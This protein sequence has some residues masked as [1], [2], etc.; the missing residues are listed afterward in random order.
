MA[1]EQVFEIKI[2]EGATASSL[3]TQYATDLETIKRLN[4]QI[5]NID[6]I[7]AGKPLKLPRIEPGKAPEDYRLEIQSGMEKMYKGVYGIEFARERL[8]RELEQKFPFVDVW[9]DIYA[10]IPNYY[11]Q[12]IQPVFAETKA[13]NIPALKQPIWQ[14]VGLFISQNIVQPLKERVADVAVDILQKLPYIPTPAEVFTEAKNKVMSTVIRPVVEKIEPW[15][16]SLAKKSETVYSDIKLDIKK[17][18]ERPLPGP[19]LSPESIEK[20]EVWVK[21]KVWEPIKASVATAWE[22]KNLMGLFYPITGV[23]I[24]QQEA[25]I[26]LAKQKYD[27]EKLAQLDP[28]VAVGYYLEQHDFIVKQYK[29]TISRGMVF[30]QDKYG[31]I[32]FNE[33]QTKKNKEQA[34]T[35]LA[36]DYYS[37]VGNEPLTIEA[38]SKWSSASSAFVSVANDLILN[39]RKVRDYALRSDLSIESSLRGLATDLN[40]LIEDASSLEAADP[41]LQSLESEIELKKRSLSDVDEYYNTS[42][43]LW[44]T[45]AEAL[46]GKDLTDKMKTGL[47]ETD[48]TILLSKIESL[49]DDQKSKFYSLIKSLD[50]SQAYFNTRTGLLD[51]LEKPSFLQ[52]LKEIYFRDPSASKSVLKSISTILEFKDW[53]SANEE[54]MKEGIVNRLI[55]AESISETDIIKKEVLANKA[56]NSEQLDASLKLVNFFEEEIKFGQFLQEAF[57]RLGKAAKI[58]KITSN[59]E[60]LKRQKEEVEK[61]KKFQESTEA[62]PAWQI[63]LAT[64][65]FSLPFSLPAIKAFKPGNFLTGLKL[66][67]QVFTQTR[68]VPTPFW[69]ENWK[70]NKI[71][72]ANGQKI[73]FVSPEVEGLKLRTIAEVSSDIWK[74]FIV[75]WEELMIHNAIPA[76]NATIAT[77]KESARQGGYETIVDG[78][79]VIK[80]AQKL[81][82]AIYNAF[83]QAIVDPPINLSKEDAIT[84]GFPYWKAAFDYY[85]NPKSYEEIYIKDDTKVEFKDGELRIGGYSSK[86]LLTPEDLLR[87]N[88]Q[89]K[90]SRW[91]PAG[92]KLTIPRFYQAPRFSDLIDDTQRY[93]WYKHNPGLATFV[94]EALIWFLP[95]PFIDPVFSLVNMSRIGGLKLASRLGIPPMLGL[96]E[97]YKVEKVFASTKI[98]RIVQ[99]A[100]VIDEELYK[101]F[102]LQGVAWSKFPAWATEKLKVPI[103][104]VRAEIA[105]TTILKN[106]RPEVAAAALAG[107]TEHK[108]MTNFRHLALEGDSIIEG[109]MQKLGESKSFRNRILLALYDTSKDPGAAVR[110]VFTKY[111]L[112]TFDVL[113]VGDRITVLKNPIEVLYEAVMTNFPNRN[114]LAASEAF[115]KLGGYGKD[116][117]L[118]VYND[119]SLGPKR[120]IN[121]PDKLTVFNQ[122]Y[123]MRFKNNLNY[124]EIYDEVRQTM[125]IFDYYIAE[126]EVGRI[127][128]MEGRVM[129]RLPN[130]LE[131]FQ[132]AYP[133]NLLKRGFFERS[134]DGKGW[135]YQFDPDRH[136]LREYE[137][138]GEAVSPLF[139]LRIS[140]MK[141]IPVRTVGIRRWKSKIVPEVE[142]FYVAEVDISAK[143]LKGSVHTIDDWSKELGN[144]G[145]VWDRIQKKELRLSLAPPRI[146]TVKTWISED[147]ATTIYLWNTLKSNF[148]DLLFPSSFMNKKLQVFLKGEYVPL[149][150]IEFLKLVSLPEKIRFKIIESITDLSVLLPGNLVKNGWAPFELRKIITQ[151]QKAEISEEILELFF[152]RAAFLDFLKGSP[153]GRIF[154]SKYKSEL[155]K[156]PKMWFRNEATLDLLLIQSFGFKQILPHFAFD[157]LLEDRL[158]PLQRKLLESFIERYSDHA[159]RNIFKTEQFGFKRF[160]DPIPDQIY[161]NTY[162]ESMKFYSLGY[163]EE[164]INTIIPKVYGFVPP[165]KLTKE[166][167]IIL[168]EDLISQRVEQNREMLRNLSKAKGEE[169][170]T[171][172]KGI[173]KRPLPL[174]GTQISFF[175]NFQEAAKLS[176]VE[177]AK[178]LAIIADG[179]KLLVHEITPKDKELIR[180]LK[181]RP[182]L[183]PEQ[184]WA[185]YKPLKAEKIVESPASTLADLK[186]AQYGVKGSSL[187][188]FLNFSLPVKGKLSRLFTD[189][190]L[191]R[192]MANLPNFSILPE[193]FQALPFNLLVKQRP[194]E[195]MR[196]KSVL[197]RAFKKTSLGRMF[198]KEIQK[199]T[200]ITATF[201]K[202]LKIE[203]ETF[204]KLW[205]Q[206]GFPPE[207]H[208][209]GGLLEMDDVFQEF[210][211]LLRSALN[212]IGSNSLELSIKKGRIVSVTR[213]KIFKT[214]LE[215]VQEEMGY[216]GDF[217]GNRAPRLTD[218]VASKT[219]PSAELSTELKKFL[220]VLHLDSFVDE[221]E[222]QKML[223][224]VHELRNLTSSRVRLLE[225]MEEL[226]IEIY[227]LEQLINLAPPTEVKTLKSSLNGRKKALSQISKVLDDLDLRIKMAEG[228]IES[229]MALIGDILFPVNS[230]QEMLLGF[231]SGKIKY[232][233]NAFDWISREIITLEK[234]FKSL[235]QK[236]TEF[237]KEK[238]ST[239]ELQKSKFALEKKLD[240]LK[241]LKDLLPTIQ[242]IGKVGIDSHEMWEL[243]RNRLVPSLIRK[244]KRLDESLKALALPLRTNLPLSKTERSIGQALPD[245]RVR[246]QKV[247]IREE[248]ASKILNDYLGADFG[249]PKTYILPNIIP[250]AWPSKFSSQLKIIDS[251]NRKNIKVVIDNSGDLLKIPLKDIPMNFRVVQIPELQ[252]LIG[253]VKKGEIPSSDEI[254]GLLKLRE[255]FISERSIAILDSD[256]ELVQQIVDRLVSVYIST[257]RRNAMKMAQDLFF[258]RARMI[259]EGVP[260]FPFRHPWREE[261]YNKIFGNPEVLANQTRKALEF[262]EAVRYI[263][264]KYPIDAAVKEIEV[265]LAKTDLVPVS[266]ITKKVQTWVIAPDLLHIPSTELRKLAIAVKEQ[267][268][269]L[270]LLRKSTSGE[271]LI[272]EYLTAEKVAFIELTIDPKKLL[273]IIDNPMS[274]IIL[275]SKIPP[276]VYAIGRRFDPLRQK[277]FD[278]AKTSLRLFEPKEVLQKRIEREVMKEINKWRFDMKK[279]V[280]EFISKEVEFGWTKDPAKLLAKFK[281]YLNRKTAKDVFR[282]KVIGKLNEAEENLK[283]ELLRQSGTTTLSKRQLDYLK[284]WRERQ[285]N[286]IQ[287]LEQV[288]KFDRKPGVWEQIQADIAKRLELKYARD[289]NLYLLQGFPLGAF[290]KLTYSEGFLKGA[291]RLAVAIPKLYTAAII[292]FGWIRSFWVHCVLYWRIAWYLKNSYDDGIR[293]SLAARNIEYFFNAQAI[294]G[295]AAANFIK[296]FAQDIVDIPKAFVRASKSEIAETANVVDRG[297]A[298]WWDDA[299]KEART[300]PYEIWD[301]QNAANVA[302]KGVWQSLDS[303]MYRK[304]LDN[305]LAFEKAVVAGGIKTPKGELLTKD[306]LD[307]LSAAG[308]FQISSDAVYLRK[309]ISM[310]SESSVWKRL[311]KRAYVLE[312]DIETFANFTEQARRQ[313]L[314][315]D[316]LFNKAMSLAETQ[317]KTWGYMFNYRDLSI[318]G[319]TFRYFFPFYSFNANVVRLYL[320][321][322][323]K[324]P[325]MI[326]AARAFLSSWSAATRTLPP[327]A[328]DR[329]AIGN[330]FYWYPW[331]SG[332]QFLYFFMDPVKTLQEFAENPLKVPLGFG[333][334]PYWTSVLE[335]VTK[336]RY[337][338][339]SQP[340]MRETGWTDEEIEDYIK[341]QNLKRDISGDWLQLAMNFM[342]FTLVIKSL[343]EVDMYNLMDGMSI[344]RSTAFRELA[345]QFG[346]NIKKW[347]E[348]DIMAQTYYDS[349]PHIRNLIKKELIAENPMLWDTLQK[350]WAKTAYLAA[351]KLAKKDPVKATADLQIRGLLSIYY[352]MEDDKP[353]SGKLWLEKRPEVKEALDK[354]F[355]SQENTSPWRMWQNAEYNLGVLA[356]EVRATIDQIYEKEV[357]QATQILGIDIPFAIPGDKEKF[358]E[359]F[360]DRQGNL[361]VATAKEFETIV[362][363]DFIKDVINNSDKSWQE[364]VKDVAKLRYHEWLRESLTLETPEEKTYA[365]KMSFWSAILPT[366]INVLPE[367]E[368]Q[369]YW[370][371]YWKYFEN[372]FT[373]EQ[374]VMYYVSLKERKGEWYYEYRMKMKEYINTWSDLISGFKQKDY[375]YFENFYKQPNWFQE[376]YFLNYP[377]KAQW[378][379]FA[380]DWTSQLGQIKKLEESTGIFQTDLRKKT[381]DFF[382]KHE[383]LVKLWDKDNPGFYDYMKAW[384]K[385]FTETESDPQKYFNSF[386]QQPDWFQK[387]FF[388]DNPDKALY[389]PVIRKW[390]IAI[391]KD[392]ENFERTGIRSHIARDY[393][394]SWKNTLAGKA[395]AKANPITPTKSL[396]DYLEIWNTIIIQNEENPQAFFELFD[397]QPDWFKDHYFKKYPDKKLYYSFARDLGKQK[398][399]DFGI[400]FWKP[401]FETARQA[402]EKYNPGFLDYMTFWKR[403]SQFAQAKQ[404]DLYFNFYFA[405]NNEKFRTR[406][407]KNNPGVKERFEALMEYQFLPAGTFEE[408]RIRR[409]FLK[410]HPTIVESWQKNISIEDAE[411]R[412]KMEKYY[413]IVD[414]IPLQGT[415][416]E[417]FQEV[418]KYELEADE[419]LKA[420]PDVVLFF[421]K[422]SKKYLGAETAVRA[423]VNQYFS[424]LDPAERQVFIQDHPEIKDFF[425]NNRPPGL[426]LVL[427]LQD[428]YFALPKAFRQVFLDIHPE[429]LDY[430]GVFL[431]P[432]S[433]FFRPKESAPIRTILNEV[434]VCFDIYKTGEWIQAEKRRLALPSDYSNPGD[435]K[436]SNWLRFQIYYSAM[437]TWSKLAG[438]NPFMAIYFFRQLPDWIRDIY[439]SKHPEKQYLSKYPLNRFAEEPLRIEEGLEPDL[440]WAYKM[441]YKYGRNIPYQIE[442]QVRDI[443]IENGVWESRKNWTKNQW[444]EYWLNRTLYLNEV[445]KFDFQN[446]PL[447][448]TEL[449]KVIKNYPFRLL[450]QPFKRPVMGVIHPF[451]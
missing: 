189:E 295:A 197:L 280:P 112:S 238:I 196:F 173:K 220:K 364:Y 326:M 217:I 437:Q 355:D 312:A 93:E 134:P 133:E 41:S 143:S 408:R 172:V 24:K 105:Q 185:I 250:T 39:L 334:D 285:E 300:R 65:P 351:A 287:M 160:V 298:K 231:L 86:N 180:F 154:L 195:W 224:R 156:A 40:Q 433:S 372:Y 47:S 430:W 333:W 207:V 221:K 48:S 198:L 266:D 390:V 159:V 348:L 50:A 268:A 375:P 409:E 294:F 447:L 368:A 241:N 100:Q 229:T 303:V 449:E 150:T 144:P 193:K 63:G 53:Y 209:A 128:A 347:D 278:Q 256:W 77:F 379:P 52:G 272:K 31:N 404:W 213:S 70:E 244:F 225:R 320:N 321:I 163:R 388:D 201:R 235:D 441:L 381:S 339:I 119:W 335:G 374:K 369:K 177:Q 376:I 101:M 43:L 306:M 146:K 205:T 313:L 67:W 58:I 206:M 35:D 429:L 265:T 164:A 361:K 124:S 377:N 293:G 432:S 75:G 362:G 81:D 435:S 242:K 219:L 271:R 410:K 30:G 32:E 78:I 436:E 187:Y 123:L 314:V 277:I 446:L 139:G 17:E 194:E 290:E 352:A 389:Y 9:K 90:D 450:P 122:E 301:A 309:L 283:Q 406:H 327:W 416:K 12:K 323:A 422:N 249:D 88:P 216:L 175:T 284:T 202:S 73:E 380:K 20:G 84:Y 239:E 74:W 343:F 1:E 214:G 89:L 188:E 176:K 14:Q 273:A 415:G 354:W 338:D 419:F 337:W 126:V 107:L 393:F 360:F 157:L 319:R 392:Q 262:P 184:D 328:R 106:L 251:L 83:K 304:Q 91:I 425:V 342:P 174:E 359:A 120:S 72:L 2:P 281:R 274:D 398:P 395:Y 260:G 228:S 121:T 299:L 438:K 247:Q 418:K 152:K 448:R 210:Y 400:Y 401:E 282:K 104:L 331:W 199:K 324:N 142:K 423:L 171:I 33:E 428:Q 417:Y 385:I 439:Y 111:G 10:K 292:P 82:F 307:Y 26:T 136:L 137:V 204:S 170:L 71:I 412:K 25:G 200:K 427:K 62:A 22:T 286:V 87:W 148:F 97:L 19:K 179:K 116:Y 411:I 155:E 397:K 44:W 341:K 316:L 223:D 127:A 85:K 192:L 253:I 391:Q 36:T 258:E 332:Y 99:R 69:T 424:I 275:A 203:D 165:A 344:W 158:L 59:L 252:R 405:S 182:E 442:D 346:I 367:K 212:G 21:E 269:E 353:N 371:V 141:I 308:L 386:Y 129:V 162:E 181:S 51:L 149:S 366:D 92:T 29:E 267:G 151:I 245:L 49:T 270:V 387:R 166:Q 255:L 358:V 76:I 227:R 289:K 431:T 276:Y 61:I 169:I 42:I 230:Y 237:I 396:I 330:D 378:Y 215:R 15:A 94:D 34:L 445:D 109:V 56:L 443:M 302:K 232:T 98:A 38:L 315:H 288:V 66:G 336:K 125:K 211:G 130:N 178:A 132:P 27:P 102:T 45:G 138:V 296:K 183:I 420:N 403:L 131:L 7:Q 117:F 218:L 261:Q 11:E 305:I 365:K 208:A 118:R 402:W 383:D 259:K 16:E 384:Q 257:N 240:D 191:L 236:I 263:T 8:G 153:N 311:K 46:V 168:A 147:R 370:N 13:I 329:I 37:K 340:I 279:Y 421:Q 434:N 95:T 3:A 264:S 399:E 414:S 440:I 113:A 18:F 349:P 186:R 23:G 55:K 103:D 145:A 115:N 246:L 80:P 54:K 254:E 345:K 426:R 382:W 57:D 363:R 243:S 413:E 96:K 226:D 79:P 60:D 322:F 325:R 444:S 5:L 6:I 28:G 234:S 350:Y 4:P 297:L 135:R 357:I 64:L 394:D 222:F 233:G 310:M 317:M 167:K 140:E 190:G 373:D 248:N 407:Q 318:V 68:F 108:M 161:L 356:S 114:A 451:I 291:E 110:E